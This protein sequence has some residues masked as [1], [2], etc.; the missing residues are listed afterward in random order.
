MAG[1][2]LDAS[3]GENILLLDLLNK[4]ISSLDFLI[5]YLEHN[6][7]KREVTY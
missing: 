4:I 6:R 3:N 1:Y 7:L 5:F 2:K